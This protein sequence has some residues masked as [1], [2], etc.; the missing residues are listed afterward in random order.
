MRLDISFALVMAL[1]GEHAGLA[2]TLEKAASALP[3]LAMSP[4]MHGTIL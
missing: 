4:V 1:S 3:L 2:I